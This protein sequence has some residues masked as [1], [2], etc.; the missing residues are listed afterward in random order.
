M[1]DRPQVSFKRQ[2]AAS[3]L[4]SAATDASTKSKKTA[5]GSGSGGA[6]TEAEDDALR[7]LVDRYG[8]GAWAQKRR[9][10]GGR[11]TESAL[12][13]RWHFLTTSTRGKSG[14]GRG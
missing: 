5:G 1:L 14:K 8:V 6:W 3:P 4:H 11:R 10:L 9:Q 7:A 13:Y 12:R 2:R